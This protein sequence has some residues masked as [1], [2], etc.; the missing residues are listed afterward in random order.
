LTQEELLGIISNNTFSGLR[1]EL[2]YLNW[3]KI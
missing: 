3:K 2:E 1:A